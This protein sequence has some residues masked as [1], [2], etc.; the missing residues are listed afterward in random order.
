M[1]L[2]QI[3]ASKAMIGIVFNNFVLYY[4]ILYCIVLKF[5]KPYSNMNEN[6]H[7]NKFITGIFPCINKMV[8]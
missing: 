7:W 6:L 2:N 8:W 4:V 3:A 5:V 1:Y